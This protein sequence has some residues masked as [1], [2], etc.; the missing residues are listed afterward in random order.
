[1]LSIFLEGYKSIGK[2]SVVW[3][4]NAVKLAI[5]AP[6][7]Y[8]AAHQGIVGLAMVYIPVQILE[9]PAALYLAN[10]LIGVSPVA[11]ARAATTPLVTTFVMSAAVVIVELLLTRGAHLSNTITLLACL[12]TAAVSYLGTIYV[13]DRRI[14]FEARATLVKGL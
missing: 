14:I 2:P 1:M 13:F 11:V 3:W 10:R 8:V 6:A 9:F 12:L 4:Y 5:M 7:M